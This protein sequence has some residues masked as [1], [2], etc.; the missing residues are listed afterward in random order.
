MNVEPLVSSLVAKKTMMP[1]MHAQGVKLAN[2]RLQLLQVNSRRDFLMAAILLVDQ[3]QHHQ[4]RR[5]TMCVKPWLSQRVTLGHYDTLM[6]ELMRESRTHAVTTSPICAWNW[7]CTEYIY[8]QQ[9]H[10]T[11]KC[12]LSI[13]IVGINSKSF[14]WTAESVQKM[15]F[16]Q[17]LSLIHI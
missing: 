15:T 1:L 10:H 4:Q 5:R 14:P 8:S 6:P 9:G 13:L 3:R 11:A 16:I 7:K 2:L 17:T 12:P